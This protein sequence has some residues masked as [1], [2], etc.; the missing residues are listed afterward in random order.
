M[1]FIL[2]ILWPI[3][4]MAMEREIKITG[5]TMG[6][7]YQVKVITE[8]GI[9]AEKLQKSIENRL[10][11]INQSMSTYIPDSEISRFNDLSRAGGVFKVS[12]DFWSVMS[13]A[14]R[15][16]DLTEGAWDGTVAP[17]VNLWG[18]GSK[19]T[20]DQVPSATAI[21]AM[22]PV[23]GFDLVEMKSGRQLGKKNAAVTL[24]L[25]S[26]AKGY[27]VDH[28]VQLLVKKGFNHHLVEIGGETYA[29]GRRLD[30]QPWRVGINRPERNAPFDAV[31][32]V[33]S[34]SN[35][36]LATS[37]DYRNYFESNGR[38]YGH[39][40]DP[41][42]G[43]PVTNGIVSVSVLADTCTLADGLATGIMVMGL[44]KGLA[45]V[46]RLQQV[47]CLIVVRTSDGHLSDHTSRAFPA[48]NL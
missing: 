40:I 10:K 11:N 21:N 29:A 39:V 19:K 37:G 3:I 30:G 9:D 47:E 27:A 24:D 38:F 28:L 14:K 46:D 33:V 12:E 25:A 7:V 45:L 13:M 32:K 26:I 17:L 42:N 2:G 1:I 41:R 18:F 16:Y 35:K 36:A 43:Y 48:E 44:E 6:T 23:V 20:V 8:N 31:Y 22:L 15:V 4:P 5:Q 34:L